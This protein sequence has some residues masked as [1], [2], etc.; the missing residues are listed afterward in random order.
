[1]NS[2]RAAEEAQGHI[3][4]LRPEYQAPDEKQTSA[5]LLVADASAV[6]V[7]SA[8]S[9]KEVWPK[10]LREQINVLLGLM[11]QGPSTAE[12]L[13]SQFKRKP[14]KAV[15]QVLSALESLGRA[16]CEGEYWSLG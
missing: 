9:K 4:W 7:V 13:A 11:Q 6:S 16:H 8:T 14:V 5:E 2:Q 15:S 12:Q 3:R 10:E 1:M